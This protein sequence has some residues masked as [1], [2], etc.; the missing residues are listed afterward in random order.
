MVREFEDHITS[1]RIY[2]INIIDEIK[3]SDVT[4]DWDHHLERIDSLRSVI[5]YLISFEHLVDTKK[6][7]DES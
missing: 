4:N 1:K 2:V 7:E 5:F 6:Q 3:Q